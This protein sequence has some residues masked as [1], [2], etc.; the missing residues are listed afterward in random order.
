MRRFYAT[1]YNGTS[2]DAVLESAHLP[3]GSFYHHF[4][5]KEAFAMAVLGEYH[6]SS[7]Q[8]LQRW[9]TNLDI[10]APERLR[11]Y[12]EEM[13]FGL[14]RGGNRQGCLVGKFSLELAP[15]SEKFST[16][17]STMLAAWRASVQAILQ[18]GQTAGTIRT[19]LPATALATLVLSSIQGAVVLC[20]AH[21]NSLPMHET[22]ATITSLILPPR[23]ATDT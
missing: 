6:K 18:E 17:L 1:G 5:S 9:A 22:C 3:K 19:D 12:M 16:L 4:S 20:L 15:T 13:A 7:A 11:G 2:L 23:R 8:R 14:E 10:P 21:K